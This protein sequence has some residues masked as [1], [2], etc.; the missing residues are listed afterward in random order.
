M[1]RQR[2]VRSAVAI[3]LALALIPLAAQPATAATASPIQGKL[4]SSTGAGVEGATVR[5]IAW[6]PDDEIEAQ[7]DGA[8]VRS[9]FVASAVSRRGGSF[10][11]EYSTSPELA[12]FANADGDI[13]F[14]LEATAGQEE[15]V[16]SFTRPYLFQSPD[17]SVATITGIPSPNV[18]AP[19]GGGGTSGG[20]TIIGCSY[21]KIATYA[22]RWV[23]VGD[24]TTTTN[25]TATFTY[26]EGATSTLGVGVSVKGTV[27]SFTANGTSTVAAKV[28]IGFPPVTGVTGRQWKTQFRFAKYGF[29]CVG[30]AAGKYRRYMVKA[31]QFVGGV[32]AVT[33]SIPA[34]THCVPY[35]ANTYWESSSEKAVTWS[36]GAAVASDIGINLSSQ[37]GFNTKTKLRFDFAAAK[38][39][40]GTNDTP[41]FASRVVA[42]P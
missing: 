3:A 2:L 25:A 27:G 19:P 14:S 36:T 13:N 34:A 6:A 5:L 21:Y 37:S 22:P 1:T 38:Q 11:I 33:Q 30:D 41:N 32:Q 12:T 35:P 24:A 40:C 9:L 8:E 31:I 29:R 18:T 4:I 26:E 39:L 42:K 15:F 7:A 28:T 10:L 16:Y 17:S 20:S 23:V